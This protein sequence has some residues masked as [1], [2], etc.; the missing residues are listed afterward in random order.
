LNGTNL[1][2][3]TNYFYTAANVQP[4]EAGIY[5][6]VV[7]NVAGSAVS[8]NAVLA[9]TVPASGA[10]YGMTL[11][12]ALI[13]SGAADLGGAVVPNGTNT[14]VW[15]EWGTNGSDGQQ[16]PMTSV[17]N[18]Y[19]LTFVNA[20]IT[21]LMA[22]DIYHYRFDASNALGMVRGADRIFS[23]GGRVK[24]WGDDSYG[25]TNVPAGLTNAVAM[26]CGSYH[27]LALRND[28]TVAGW[29]YDVFGQANAPAGLTN[30]VAVAAGFYHSLALKADGTVDGWGGNS[31]GQLNGISNLTGVVAIAAGAYHSL[32]LESGG[33]V[34]AWGYNNA[35]QT[36]VPPG[37]VN[38]CAVAAEIYS[39]LA[40]GA[41][42]T[43]TAWGDNSYGQTDVP[44]GL[45]N[46]VA[47]SAGAFHC[48]AL[49][50]D[51][52]VVAWGRDDSGQ[53]NVP[54]NLAGVTATAAGDYFNLALKADGT[55]VSWG[56]DSDGQTNL[57]AGLTNLVQLAGG[58]FHAVAIGN[59]APQA[60][61]QTANG[62]VN[63]DLTITLSA[64]PGDG[65]VLNYRVTTLPGLGTL[66]Q[67]ANGGR[68]SAVSLAAPEVADDGG[69]V[70]FAPGTNGVGIP[71][72]N[73]GFV[74]NDG[75][76]DSLPARVTV[77]I[78]LPAPPQ[79]E[80][81][82]SADG[83]T[84]TFGLEFQGSTN[85]TYSLWASTN[86]V[87]W[88]WLGPVPEISPGAYQFTDATTT[89]WAARFYRVTAP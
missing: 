42:G 54:A 37:L 2:G 30:A 78:G 19:Q 69:R 51:G 43:V 68:G 89:N 24:A 62:F 60:N 41:N 28:G 74:A 16:T 48:V 17:G 77:N 61:S 80:Q 15:F 5:S 32:A 23:P 70:V 6:V 84:G 63:H 26:T 79:M 7:T 58:V 45:S 71:Y 75:L 86:L 22:G 56:D 66:Y 8:S 72:D 52:T 3:A 53:T 14:S 82:L 59:L 33:T 12:P 49:K 47:I 87:T 44:A 9:V 27:S 4:P 76:N 50:A 11:P 21:N 13:G 1:I 46:V 40:L 39:S 10:P 81:A 20:S 64:T 85:A 34:T 83:P 18:G 29:G 65:S 36:N 88:G 25:Q 67:Y 38:V 55:V 31:S 57:P 35:G 73:F